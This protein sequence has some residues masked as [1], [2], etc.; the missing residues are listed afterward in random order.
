MVPQPAQFNYPVWDSGLSNYF[1]RE[2]I[3]QG[4]NDGFDIGWIDGA[5]PTYVQSPHLKTSQE[6]QYS[7]A[8]WIVERHASG[9]LL[10]P[11][12][13][14]TCPF[15]NVHFSPLFTVPKPDLKKRI[16]AHLSFPRWGVSV[17]DC[18]HDDAKAVQYILFREVCK[19]V[20]DLGYDARLWVVDAK[21]AYYRVPIKKK[22][23]RYMGIKY[24]GMIFIFTSLQ[25]GLGSA[26]AIYQRFA[27]AVLYIIRIRHYAL[28]TAIGGGPLI[29][30]YLDDFFG[31]H[32]D[33]I[34]AMYQV[35]MVYFW[36]WV[37]GIPTKWSKLKWPHWIQIIL[38]WLYNTR[39]MTVSLP[40]DKQDAYIELVLK[41]IRERAK[42]VVKKQL[43]TLDGCL[44]HAS[45]ATYPGKAKL[46]HLEHA[47]HIEALDYD[48]KII[49]SDAAIHEL[50]WWPNALRHMNGIPLTW[51]F[52]DPSH[53]HEVVWTD[54][55]LH[56]E[57]KEGGMGG[58]TKS[59]VA[60]QIDNDDTLLYHVSLHRQDVDIKLT[61]MIAVFVMFVYFA[62]K[63][64]FKNVHLYCDNG[65]VVSSI[66]NKRA[67]LN[68]RDLQYFVDRICDLSAEYHF[69]FWI[70]KIHGDDNVLADRLSRFKQLH[71]VGQIDP[72]KFDYI[73]NSK[74][75]SIVNDALNA[76]LDFKRVPL[77]DVR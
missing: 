5:E 67:P 18:I 40:K 9:I 47:L 29:H 52:S 55:A 16:V 24:F 66:A 17:N 13:D 61:E 57:Y 30:H 56:G 64:K 50:K 43:E 62:P 6:D 76:L 72:D 51:V 7:I 2:Y 37:L 35:L 73:D 75:I 32:P 53:Y 74:I 26:C 36:F 28:F 63:W 45:V 3:W 46:R 25:M 58:C 38:G 22:Y 12:T 11:F 44:Q 71:K 20:Y 60:Y 19:F 70:D 21:D 49:L 31:G 69:R 59:G 65:T 42:G 39:L 48:T 23:W 77:N 54:A 33:S 8:Q 27:D 10:G 68:R 41:Y 1:D 15:D 14:D 34:S 4:I